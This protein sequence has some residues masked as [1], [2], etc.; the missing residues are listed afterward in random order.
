MASIAQQSSTLHAQLSAFVADYK[1]QRPEKYGP[2]PAPV[3]QPPQ[4]FNV[5]AARAEL[6]QL[7][8]SHDPAFNYSEDYTFWR[9]EQAKADRIA[10]LRGAIAR[11]EALGVA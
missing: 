7:Q 4:A 8:A 5:E 9:A 6:A 10:S 2:R 3:K 11:H 1:A